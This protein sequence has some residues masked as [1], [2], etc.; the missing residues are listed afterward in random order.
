MPPAHCESWQWGLTVGTPLPEL[1]VGLTV[2]PRF[3][4][5]PGQCRL[6]VARPAHARPCPVLT[7][8][9]PHTASPIATHTLWKLAVGLAVGQHTAR[10]GSG[11]HSVAH[12]G[13]SRVGNCHRVP[14]VVGSGGQWARGV[15][16]CSGHDNV[17]EPRTL[18]CLP[19]FQCYIFLHRWKALVDA[20]S[21]GH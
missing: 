13:G 19:E 5:A 12:S 17:M 9:K 21:K 16:T 2:S 1:A 18:E 3:G 14:V 4:L 6:A 10:V 7:L 11:A 8:P 20:R 15:L